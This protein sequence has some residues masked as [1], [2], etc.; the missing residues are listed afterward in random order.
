MK[1]GYI[2]FTKQ[3]DIIGHIIKNAVQSD[4]P[5][6][7]IYQKDLRTPFF[8]LEGLC[9]VYRNIHNGKAFGKLLQQ[10]KAV[11][12]AL[13]K[14]DF[15][16][17]LYNNIADDAL[18][19]EKVKL[20]IAQQRDNASL[21]LNELMQ[22]EEWWSGK[23]LYDW[24]KTLRKVK[25]QNEKKEINAIK[26]V[27]VNEIEKAIS[28]VND[29]PFPFEDMEEHVHELR[30]KLRWI[31]IY[32]HS[33]DGVVDLQNVF[34][35]EPEHLKK[36]FTEKI[37]HSP[38]N[39]FTASYRYKHYLALNKSNFLALSW[40]IATIGDFKDEGLELHSIHDVTSVLKLNKAENL[41]IEAF[42]QDY[43][44]KN[45]TILEKVSDLTT[46]FIAEQVLQQL[47]ISSAE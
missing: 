11:E 32:C 10:S 37:I 23:R 8:M 2:R 27:F 3:F 46:H 6:E 41:A 4:N 7:Y 5:T 34:E 22:N 31:S 13:G 33:L 43:D 25:W 21:A 44:A 28:F 42:L 47:I 29:S 35:Q 1:L 38:F 24:N 12:D 18:L 14:Y 16:F 26:K 40:M 36:Y 17:V 39:R 9:R 15:Y 30:R 19:P 45:A 20:H